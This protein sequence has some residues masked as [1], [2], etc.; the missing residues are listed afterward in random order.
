MYS[1]PALWTQARE[2]LKVITIICANRSYAILQVIPTKIAHVQYVRMWRLYMSDDLWHERRETSKFILSRHCTYGLFCS[3]QTNQL[4]SRPQVELAKQKIHAGT[5]ARSLT[6][7]STPA[8]QWTALAAGMGVSGGLA[9][10][11]EEFCQLFSA[12]LHAD[13][14]SLIEACLV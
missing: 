14:P 12:A 3:S 10:T 8:I 2:G 6:D 4:S 1:L 5:Q 11:V 7:L 13:G 9:S